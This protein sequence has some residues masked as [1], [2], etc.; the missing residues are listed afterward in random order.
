MPPGG[1]D[2]TVLH[3]VHGGAAPVPVEV[4]LLVVPP[5]VSPVLVLVEVDEVVAPPLPEVVEVPVS[6]EEQAATIAAGTTMA[7]HA[8]QLRFII[9]A[10]SRSRGAREDRA[11]EISSSR[12]D[13]G[14]TLTTKASSPPK[15]PLG[16]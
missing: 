7:A 13:Q 14:D 10:S 3:A 11:P 15:P 5:P 9:I 8:A 12:G 1:A 6:P 16:P 2:T 4:V